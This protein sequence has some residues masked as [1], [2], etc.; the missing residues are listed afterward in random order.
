[1]SKDAQLEIS[2]KKF[3]FLQKITSQLH[4]SEFSSQATLA[5][6]GETSH[7]SVSFLCQNTCI[8]SDKEAFQEQSLEIAKL[9]LQ[10]PSPLSMIPA[11]SPKLELGTQPN[12]IVQP[13]YNVLSI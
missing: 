13:K 7:N 3:E 2:S 6:V 9:H 5:V 1:M 4:D 11:R 8:T 12:M 10:E